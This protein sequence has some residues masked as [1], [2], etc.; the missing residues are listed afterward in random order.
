MR[1]AIRACAATLLAFALL[2]L[3][4]AHAK[5]EEAAQVKDL[6][7]KI[8]VAQKDPER[9]GLQAAVEGAADVHNSLSD[10]ALRKKVQAAVGKVLR[11]AKAG[12][13]RS[14]AAAVLGR[15]NDPAGAYKQLG[16]ALPGPKDKEV[17]PF[18]LA[19]LKATAALAPEAAIAP[20]LKLMTKGKSFDAAREAATALGRY[21]A[22]KK[23]AA[24]LK[25]M[26]DTM[27]RHYA[28]AEATKA[29]PKGG[30]GDRPWKEMGEALIAALNQLTGQN[31]P[32]APE[33]IAASKAA[34]K[35]LAALFTQPLP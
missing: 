24:I 28:A 25:E 31:H 5:G 14:A 7:G 33:W 35:K 1:L 8:Q 23:R 3:P 21:G 30:T 11:D 6:L 15:M 12:E 34:K 26:L 4:G 32:G 22:S 2:P 10:A 20:L 13:A 17:S 19:A 18:Q 9:S 16:K 27:S 29:N